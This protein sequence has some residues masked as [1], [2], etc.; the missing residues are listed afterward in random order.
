MI[1]IVRFS[2]LPVAAAAQAT[3]PLPP[4]Q[5]RD[6]ERKVRAPAAV[7]AGANG[8]HGRLGRQLV[9]EALERAC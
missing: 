7:D 9:L 8:G 5:C 1:R 3:E 2:F 6:L 4:G